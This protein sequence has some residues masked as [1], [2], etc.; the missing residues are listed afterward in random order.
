MK[1]EEIHYEETRSF[2]KGHTTEYNKRQQ[3]QGI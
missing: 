3:G 1:N 2:T